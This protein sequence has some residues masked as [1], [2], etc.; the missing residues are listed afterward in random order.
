M[1]YLH[2]RE[3]VGKGRYFVFNFF[4]L[5]VENESGGVIFKLPINPI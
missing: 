1:P 4:F 2:N 3:T 5:W